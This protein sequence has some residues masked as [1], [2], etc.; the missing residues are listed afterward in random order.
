MDEQ[1][2]NFNKEVENI[3]K[4][5]IEVID[6]KNIITELKNTI[7]FDS[8]L[9]KVEEMISKT[10]QWNLPNQSRKMKNS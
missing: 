3:R 6:L 9:D 5:L 1:S 4:Y 2:K 8:R 10:E 7:G